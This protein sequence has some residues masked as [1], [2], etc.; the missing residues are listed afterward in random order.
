MNTLRRIAY[1]IAFLPAAL[2]YPAEFIIL[3]ATQEKKQ[4]L[5]LFAVILTA[6]YWLFLLAAIVLVITAYATR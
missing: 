5:S 3:P 4:K 1:V 2:I 6:V